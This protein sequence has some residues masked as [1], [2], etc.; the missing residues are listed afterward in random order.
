MSNSVVIAS[1][2]RTPIGRFCGSFSGLKGSE[3]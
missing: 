2:A 3:L 1:I